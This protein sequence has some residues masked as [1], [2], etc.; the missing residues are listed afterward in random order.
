M[1]KAAFLYR[2]RFRCSFHDLLTIYCLS[3]WI[4]S[5]CGGDF[6]LA[7]ETLGEMFDHSFPVCAFL[8][9]LLLLL[10]LLFFVVKAEISSRTLIPLFS[11][12]S[13][14]DLAQRAEMTVA[15]CSLTSCLWARFRIGSHTMPGK[16]HS[17]SSHSDF[18]GSRVHACLGV[19]CHLHFW[20]SELG[21]LRAIAV[22]RE[23]VGGGR[24]GH[25]MK[26]AQKKLTLEKKILTPLLPGSELAT[27][28]TRVRHSNQQAIPVPDN[29]TWYC[30]FWSVTLKL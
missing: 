26:S 22:T 24:D 27:F 28:R 18:V 6:F 19:T 1:L 8:C 14:S 23:G 25:R 9:V 4:K 21:L 11:P 7:C 30:K 15:E 29:C 13:H 3:H 17:T 16:R 20:Q 10:L 2:R 12:G 5:N